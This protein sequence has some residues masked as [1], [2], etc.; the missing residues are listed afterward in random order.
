MGD[1]L[2]GKRE[3]GALLWSAQLGGPELWVEV[4]E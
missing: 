1:V 3:G 2:F 4:A